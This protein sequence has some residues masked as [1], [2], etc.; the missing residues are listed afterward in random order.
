MEE[1][2]A[3][4]EKSPGRPFLPS[5]TFFGYK[6]IWSGSI[7]RARYFITPNVTEDASALTVEIWEGPWEHRLSTIEDVA[8]F[9]L[10]QEGLEMIRDHITE[11]AGKINARPKRTFEEDLARLIQA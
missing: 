9:P 10:S 6:N 2:K 11:W 3:D 8:E 5:L 7:G 1:I 4:N